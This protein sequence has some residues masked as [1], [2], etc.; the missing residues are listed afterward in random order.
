MFFPYIPTSEKA[1]IRKYNLHREQRAQAIKILLNIK[2]V[3]FGK[4]FV[5]YLFNVILLL[6]GYWGKPYTMFPYYQKEPTH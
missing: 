3:L 1:C 6:Q 5:S 4:A 2:V